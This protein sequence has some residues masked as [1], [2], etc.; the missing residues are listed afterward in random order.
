MNIRRDLGLVNIFETVVDYEIELNA[1][2]LQ[3]YGGQEVECANLTRS[4][5]P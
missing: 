4:D 3:R 1:L 5:I 2:W